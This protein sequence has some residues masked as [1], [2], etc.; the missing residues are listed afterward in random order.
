[1]VT[2]HGPSKMAVHCPTCDNTSVCEPHGYT[3]YDEPSEGPAARYSLMQC[4]RGHTL[5]VLQEEFGL[6]LRFDDDEPLRV[7]P[8]QARPLSNEVPAPLRAAHDEARKCHRAKA[9]KATVVMSGRTLEGAC[10]LHG[11]TKGVLQQRLK[12]MR[13]AGHIDGRLWEWAETLRDVRNTAAHFNEEEVSRQDAEDALAYSEAL[14]DY[15]YVLKQRF[16]AMK[17][18]RSHPDS[19]P[20]G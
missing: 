16:E 14:L 5:L 12:D 3:I 17:V 2:N 15:L 20:T 13:D 10:E 8:A 11:V 4:P 19:L 6:G 9:Y 1:M 18:R 7:Y